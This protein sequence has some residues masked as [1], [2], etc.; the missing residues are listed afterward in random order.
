MN[1]P[2]ISTVKR[3]LNGELMAV[4]YP[5]ISTVKRAINGELI[6]NLSVKLN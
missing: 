4:N 5:I 1:C 2:I 3:A 6:R